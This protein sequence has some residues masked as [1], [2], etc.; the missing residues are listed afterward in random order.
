MR[1]RQ[2]TLVSA[3]SRLARRAD[4]IPPLYCLQTVST[5]IAN[6]TGDG[7]PKSFS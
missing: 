3:Q 1:D 5:P 7:F 6:K 2:P 4:R